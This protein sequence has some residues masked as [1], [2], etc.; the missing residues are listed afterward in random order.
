MTGSFSWS[1][2]VK[3]MCL[4]FAQ[5]RLSSAGSEHTANQI[6]V[7]GARG[8]LASSLDAAIAKQPAWL[9]DVF[10]VD[11]QGNTLL[12]RLVTRENPE[13]KRPG[14]VT[15][16]LKSN[17]LPL[18]TVTLY[19]NERELKDVEDIKRLILQLQGEPIL[20]SNRRT[21]SLHATSS[22]PT[23]DA[24]S[25]RLNDSHWQARLIGDL[26]AETSKVLVGNGRPLE[27]R[28][29]SALRALGKNKLLERYLAKNV[30]NL[31]APLCQTPTLD[32]SA[33][34]IIIK[35]FIQQR[36][37]PLAL[38]T[39]TG[40]LGPL[41]IFNYLRSAF[42]IPIEIDYD[43]ANTQALVDHLGSKGEA[44]HLD[45]C[46]FSAACAS[47]F[48]SEHGTKAFG[49]V[50]VLPHT[51]HQV[52]SQKPLRHIRQLTHARNLYITDAL[53]TS[54]LFMG[55]ITSDPM[56]LPNST[57]VPQEL[58]APLLGEDPDTA[59]IL[60]FPHYHLN[61]LFNNLFAT[62]ILPVNNGSDLNILFLHSE[63]VA[64]K[65]IEASLRVL[66]QTSWQALA[67]NRMVLELTLRPVLEDARFTKF[68]Y[69]S[70]GLSNFRYSDILLGSPA[71]S[72]LACDN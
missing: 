44:S 41:A 62:D 52:V 42:G 3:A 26:I 34:A 49:P 55:E 13:M 20:T 38:G 27:E 31:F 8:S 24:L 29:I 35:N 11:S 50:M 59:A 58:A 40:S 19:I 61:V 51:S 43:F 60:W 6:L 48:I 23:S 54:H 71:R 46:N 56:R 1:S 70:C 68:F 69:E 4:L 65:Q 33:A 57:F 36:G 47:R 53:S 37:R 12:R 25:A 63:I 18:I 21:N 10:G 22:R 9:L 66:C 14:P 30:W 7:F 64:N 17:V 2:A 16:L 72:L 5:H 15:V 45:G 39:G 67:N 32:T 28:S